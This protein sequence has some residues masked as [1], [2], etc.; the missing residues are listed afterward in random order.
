MGCFDPWEIILGVRSDGGYFEVKSKL[1]N[2]GQVVI[3]GQ[4]MLDSG[5]ILR[6]PALRRH[7]A[8][9][10]KESDGDKFRMIKK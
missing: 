3:L 1:K 8:R 2:D 9:E 10:K 6:E 7:R 4:F 5:S